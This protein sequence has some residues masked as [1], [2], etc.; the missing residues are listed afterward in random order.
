MNPSS[1][2]AISPWEICINYLR[3]VFLFIF[4]M[5]DYSGHEDN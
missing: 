2:V 5:E 1:A 4:D 3:L